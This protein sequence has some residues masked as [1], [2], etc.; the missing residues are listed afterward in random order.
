MN[1]I[2]TLLSALMSV[3]DDQEHAYTEIAETSPWVAARSPRTSAELWRRIVFSVLVTNV[4][5]HLNNHDPESIPVR[6]HP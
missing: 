4:D 6:P 1:A 3:E 2:T 5:D